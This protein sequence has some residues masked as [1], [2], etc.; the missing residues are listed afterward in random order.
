MLST[1]HFA[2]V[3]G[4]IDRIGPPYATDNKIEFYTVK[5]D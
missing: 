4:L 1:W 5:S 2:L 3:R